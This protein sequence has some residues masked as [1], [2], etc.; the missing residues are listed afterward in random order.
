MM[1]E[2][3]PTKH[4]FEQISATEK[5]LCRSCARFDYCEQQLQVEYAIHGASSFC[6]CPGLLKKVVQLTVYSQE[7]DNGD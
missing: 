4:E 3:C 2:N 1:D 6:S 5:I 7:K